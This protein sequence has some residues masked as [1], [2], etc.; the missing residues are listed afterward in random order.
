VP[1][2]DNAAAGA[3]DLDCVPTGYVYIYTPLPS[4]Q[5]FNLEGYAKHHKRQNDWNPD[6]LTDEGL[7]TV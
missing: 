2:G 4:A 1:P 6:L 7:S 5:W 3:S